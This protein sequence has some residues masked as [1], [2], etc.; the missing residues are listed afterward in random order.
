MRKSWKWG[1]GYSYPFLK[2]FGQK[3]VTAIH[4]ILKATVTTLFPH[5]LISPLYPAW[6]SLTKN[7][8]SARQ[9]SWPLVSPA[10]WGGPL[11]AQ[12]SGFGPPQPSRVG[13]VPSGVLAATPLNHGSCA[14]QA[15]FRHTHCPTH[16]PRDGPRQLSDGPSRVE[17]VVWQMPPWG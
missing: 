5:G 11:S 10:Q 2:D 13:S 15:F 17:C 1:Q 9:R 12:H 7:R 3:F 8:P 14:A 6:C 16:R 4:L